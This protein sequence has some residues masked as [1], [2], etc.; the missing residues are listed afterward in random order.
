M[1]GGRLLRA[2]RFVEA[3]A[4][5]LGLAVLAGFLWPK[6]EPEIITSASD[7]VLKRSAVRGRDIDRAFARIDAPAMVG[8]GSAFVEAERQTG[9]NALFLAAIAVHES[10]KG[11]SDIAR[12]KNN[13]FG[14]GA[15]DSNPFESAYSFATR[16]AGILYVASRLKALYIDTWGLVTIDEIGRRYA[17]DTAW[18]DKVYYWVRRLQNEIYY[19]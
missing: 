14:W 12:L 9:I 11:T 5:V 15:Y 4:V 8:L 1:I 3:S 2:K 6:P 17:S 18:A 16:E 13:L 7:S 10:N 19:R